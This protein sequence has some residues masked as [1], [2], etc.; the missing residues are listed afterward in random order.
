MSCRYEYVAMG[1][2]MCGCCGEKLCVAAVVR[3]LYVWAVASTV[4]NA[5]N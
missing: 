3:N 4:E 5:Q 2:I 1:E